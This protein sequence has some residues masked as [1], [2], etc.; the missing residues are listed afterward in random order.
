M[1]KDEIKKK[2]KSWQNLFFH[3]TERKKQKDEE[4]KRN[5]NA[6]L[7]ENLPKMNEIE[8]KD[9]IKYKEN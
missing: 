4:R 3:N 8:K 1:K 6:N 7:H 5:I 2:K 9:R